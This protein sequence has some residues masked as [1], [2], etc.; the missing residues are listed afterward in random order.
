[1]QWCDS[2][3]NCADG[4]DEA[5]CS[6]VS[7]LPES[8]VCDGYF[9]CPMGGDEIGCFGCDQ[10]SYSCYNSYEEYFANNKS[11]ISMCYTMLEKCDGFYNCLN[12]RDEL[13]CSMLANNL[14]DH[15]S[16][17]VSYTEGYLFRN[18]KGKWYPVCLDYLNNGNSICKDFIV[19]VHSSPLKYLKPIQMPGPFIN[20]LKPAHLITPEFNDTCFV[21]NDKIVSTYIT[22]PPVKCGTESSYVERHTR[23]TEV[24]AN[25]LTNENENVKIVGGNNANSRSWPYVVAIFRNGVFLCG[26]TIFNEYWIITAAHCLDQASAFFY[27]IR[28]GLLRRS[29]FAPMVQIRHAIEVVLNSKYNKKNLQND[30]GMIKVSSPFIFNEWV[31]PICILEQRKTLASNPKVG[32]YCTV[33]GWGALSENGFECMFLF[34]SFNI[35]TYIYF[36]FYF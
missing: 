29:S 20:L 10:F 3:V 28:A 12:E 34:I 17:L 2:Y 1:M 30:I 8:R 22:C 24:N 25:E 19:D 15:L 36:I 5:F 23:H 14:D 26:G 27:E 7:R 11:S 18:N 9:D 21:T 4:S 33:I 35:I 6:C 13:N 16:F 32:S 31:R